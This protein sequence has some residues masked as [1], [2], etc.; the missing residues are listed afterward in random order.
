MNIVTAYKYFFYR[1]YKWQLKLGDKN[2]P[3]VTA[4]LVNSILLFLNLLTVIIWFQI[5]TGY[6]IQIENLYAITGTSL[7]LLINYFIFLYNNKFKRI[8]AEFDSETEL[9]SARRGTLC[10][11]YEIG[12]FLSFFGS[13]LIF[14]PTP[15]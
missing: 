4:I 6:K 12:T 9:Q 10:L 8:I 7:I 13:I 11:V 3:Q 5:M 2:I 1:T 15:K 14:S